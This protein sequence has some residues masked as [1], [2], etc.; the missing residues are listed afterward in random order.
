MAFVGPPFGL[1]VDP[2]SYPFASCTP[3][4]DWLWLVCPNG[5][6]WCGALPP[7]KIGGAKTHPHQRYPTLLGHRVVCAPKFGWSVSHSCFR[8]G[9]RIWQTSG[10]SARIP[11]GRID[12]FPLSELA[13]PLDQIG[14][15]K[16]SEPSGACLSIQH[17]LSARK[18]TSE[19]T[20]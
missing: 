9:C 11:M 2:Q 3:I 7:S 1:Y 17:Q 12:V 16:K 20:R 13:I 4:Q 18:L 5:P 14:I 10:R 19:T 6:H 15:V 8:I